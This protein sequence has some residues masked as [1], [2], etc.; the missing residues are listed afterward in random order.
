MPAYVEKRH[1]TV[2]FTQTCPMIFINDLSLILYATYSKNGEKK[3][4]MKY[5]KKLFHVLLSPKY[6]TFCQTRRVPCN[7]YYKTKWRDF[8]Y[9]DCSI[10]NAYYSTAQLRLHVL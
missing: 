6:D 2:Y 3:F 4:N 7:N 10:C 9:E 5:T 8:K 1:F